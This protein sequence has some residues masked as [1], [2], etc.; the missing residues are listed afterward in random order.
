MIT[1]D[2]VGDEVI[3]IFEP[4]QVDWIRGAAAEYRGREDRAGRRRGTGGEQPGRVGA[5]MAQL[6]AD[7]PA[8]GGVFVFRHWGHRLAWAWMLE[9]LRVMRAGGLP[10]EERIDVWL[11]YTIGLLLAAGD[12]EDVEDVPVWGRFGR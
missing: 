9:E 11:G 2:R 6:L 10:V 3:C 1:W 4:W 8:V 7:L 5:M 12:D